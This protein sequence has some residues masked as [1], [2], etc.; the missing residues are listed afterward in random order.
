MGFPPNP[1]RNAHEDR[2]VVEGA[3]EEAAGS[4][5]GRRAAVVER[6]QHRLGHGVGAVVLRERELLLRFLGT[7]VVFH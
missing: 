2:R 5:G 7:R 4:G 6:R 1:K 3:A